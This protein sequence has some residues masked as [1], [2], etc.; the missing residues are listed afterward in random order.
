MCGIIGYYFYLLVAYLEMLGV[1]GFSTGVIS[2]LF[3]F[4]SEF[5]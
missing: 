3:G 1:W 2:I 4:I 5:K